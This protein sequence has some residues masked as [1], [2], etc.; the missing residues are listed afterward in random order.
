ML[1][2]GGKLAWSGAC[3]DGCPLLLNERDER[4]D[5]PLT[6]ACEGE[7]RIESQSIPISSPSWARSK[8]IWWLDD[9]DGDVAGVSGEKK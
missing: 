6:D 1:G 8:D 2:D 7:N 3:S 4:G 5:V 9:V